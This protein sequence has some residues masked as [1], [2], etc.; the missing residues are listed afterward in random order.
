MSS[1]FLLLIEFYQRVI[2][3]RKGFHCAHHRV[4]QGDTCSN[5]VKYLIRD[6]GVVSA[7]PLIRVRFKECREAYNVL[8][9]NNGSTHRADIC[10]PCDVSF[11]D[12]SFGGGEGSSDTCV[13]CCDFIPTDGPRFSRRTWR[14]ILLGL[15]IVSLIAAYW[16]YGRGINVVYLMDNGVQQNSV[17]DLLTKRKQPSVRVLLEV[18]GRK[19]YTETVQLDSFDSE[20]KL[21]LSNGPLSYHIDRLQIMDARIKLGDEAVV[22]SQI[23][24]E[25][26]KPTNKGQGKRFNYR[27]KRRWHFF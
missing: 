8:L 18:N 27:I 17:L 1:L 6:K 22:V 14:R 26:N 24:E 13:S 4:H 15:C 19:Y 25:F 9:N 20:Y 21:E 11:G 7:W 10:V 12:C 16:F 5:A 23:L 2:S 3:P